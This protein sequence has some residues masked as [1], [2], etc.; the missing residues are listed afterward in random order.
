MYPALLRVLEEEHDVGLR[1]AAFEAGLKL[2]IGAAAG[3]ERDR[4]VEAPRRR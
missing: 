2:A 4:D 1:R 3:L